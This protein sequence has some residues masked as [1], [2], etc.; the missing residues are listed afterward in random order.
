MH[1]KVQLMES[2]FTPGD[3]FPTESHLK[4][5]K[6]GNLS[7]HADVDISEC[8]S[9]QLITFQ[10]V[11]PSSSSEE[12]YKNMLSLCTRWFRVVLFLE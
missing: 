7:T 11:E 4:E 5:C 2:S 6:L 12:S 8:H 9:Y 10:Y 1:A 3:P